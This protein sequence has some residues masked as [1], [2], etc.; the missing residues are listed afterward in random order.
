MSYKKSKFK[1]K[2]KKHLL[3]TCN[4]IYFILLELLRNHSK[5]TF[6][7]AAIA[8][9]FG[10]YKKECSVDVYYW[11]EDKMKLQQIPWTKDMDINTAIA[12]CDRIVVSVKCVFICSKIN[13]SPLLSRL[14]RIRKTISVWWLQY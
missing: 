14:N 9:A 8:F 1:K 5:L 12:C 10:Y 7:D 3:F 2:K 11:I 4:N 6:Y 13:F